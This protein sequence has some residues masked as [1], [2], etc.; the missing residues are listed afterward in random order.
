MHGRSVNEVEI[1][2]ALSPAGPLLIKGASVGADPTRPEIEFTRTRRLGAEAVYVP[3]SSVRGALRTHCERIAR[4]VGG[5]G[6]DGRPRLSCNPVTNVADGPNYSCSRRLGELAAQ[7]RG[8]E[9]SG[10]RV[11]R[12]S[13][14][15]C[16]LFG[17]GALAGRI[18]VRDA[19]V[20]A[21]PRIEARAGI[22]V[23][24]LYGSTAD[25]P[26]RYEVVTEGRFETIIAVH[27]FTLAQLGLVGLALRDLEAGRLTLGFGRTRGLGR[28]GLA[29]TRLTVRYP[30]CVVEDG[31]LVTLAG[32]RVGLAT[33]LHGAGA[34]PNTAGYGL[35]APD[36]VAV[37][38]GAT[39][40]EDGWGAVTLAVAAE[41]LALT[42]LWRACV[43]R[44]ADRVGAAVG[45]S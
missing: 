14:A 34:F 16:Q 45:P 39:A 4:T 28:V 41:P 7:A 43:A 23:D 10:Q 32:G 42:D 44:W 5:T 38:P 17:N 11:Y 12:E 6:A 19:H 20:T 13:C 26:Y 25:G 22:A 27:N 2:V 9:P 29:I 8:R 36:S 21:A 35:P 40:V 30:G 15:V 24:R 3:G 37:S 18:A 33:M 1:A 31:E